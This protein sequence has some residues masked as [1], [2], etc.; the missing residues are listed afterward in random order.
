MGRLGEVEELANLATYLVSD[1]SS[2]MTGE[3]VNFDGGQLPSMAGMFNNLSQVNIRRRS[4][5]IIY[6]FLCLHDYVECHM[7]VVTLLY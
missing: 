5:K 2:W 7:A 3:V 6:L 4:M 1:Y